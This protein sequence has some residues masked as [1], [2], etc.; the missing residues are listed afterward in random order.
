MNLGDVVNMDMFNCKTLKPPPRKI[1]SNDCNGDPEFEKADISCDGSQK[2]NTDLGLLNIGSNDVLSALVPGLGLISEFGVFETKCKRKKFD[3]NKKDCCLRN[4][5]SG[6]LEKKLIPSANSKTCDPKFVPANGNISSECND[7]YKEFCQTHEQ[8]VNEP[9]CIKWLKSENK[10]A[11]TQYF[12]TL[13]D[14]CVGGNLR[15]KECVDNCKLSLPS[16]EKGIIDYCQQKI[17]YHPLEPVLEDPLCDS[18]CAIT[19]NDSV[20]TLCDVIVKKSCDQI[21]PQTGATNSNCNCFYENT[22]KIGK[23]N[24]DLEDVDEDIRSLP[25]VCTL[26]SCRG[27]GYKTIAQKDSASK[28]PPCVQINGVRKNIGDVSNITQINQCSVIQTG[29]ASMTGMT[30]PDALFSSSMTGTSTIPPKEEEEVKIVKN[31]KAIILAGTI[32]FLILIYS[33]SFIEI[34]KKPL[35]YYGILSLLFGFLVAGCFYLDSINIFFSSQ[36]IYEKSKTAEQLLGDINKLTIE[37]SQQPI[38]DCPVGYYCPSGEKASAI[39]CSNGSYCPGNLNEIN[40]PSGYYC[41]DPNQKNI[42]PP[43]YYCESQKLTKLMDDH[44]CP[45]GNYCDKGGNWPPVKCPE[46][47]YCPNPG[48][49]SEMS[50]PIGSYCPNTGMSSPIICPSGYYCN[51][52]GISDLISIYKCPI[53]F[54]C[55]TGGN[56]P[57]VICPNTTYCGNPGNYAPPKCQAGYYCKDG[58]NLQP[59]KCPAGSYCPAGSSSPILCE[60]GYYQPK[61]EQSS[62]IRCPAGQYCGDLN[63]NGGKG[64]VNPSPA[65]G[66]YTVDGSIFDSTQWN[67]SFV[68]NNGATKQDVEFCPSGAGWPSLYTGDGTT[69][70]SYLSGNPTN[71]TCCTNWYPSTCTPKNIR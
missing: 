49:I 71:P 34:Y 2:P 38:K 59:V 51:T 19:T 5:S 44:K 31:Y 60:P 29:L 18:L 62:C 27:S 68:R 57:P 13:S 33:I 20:K 53:G 41:P 15:K 47:S 28:C 67:N 7:I 36:R 23:Q 1:N 26:S 55:P 52:G 6:L 65:D 63:V 50:C 35:Y 58:G 56:S 48:M 10:D 8:F 69:G 30:G 14:F 45:I 24:L 11:K 22:T 16:C 42:C 40:C 12:K 46:G 9:I 21:Y 54:Y 64:T 70:R 25:V 17:K 37:E 39:K 32:L 61:T 43:G 66:V 4:F 3:G